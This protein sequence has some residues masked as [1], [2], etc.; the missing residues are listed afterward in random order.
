MM[1]R[2][3]RIPL[4]LVLGLLSSCG[5][6]VSDPEEQVR[7]WLSAMHEAAEEKERG[8]IVAGISPAYIDVRGNSR[9]DIDKL[10][11]VYFFRQNTITLLSN[12]DE[13]NVIGGTAAEVSMTVG[14]AGTNSS[15]LG[16]SADAYRFELEL[17]LDGDDWKLISARWGELG[18]RLR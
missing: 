15:A 17:E 18:E 8:G 2:V 16:I 4:L 12:I 10:L 9:D 3:T 13:V 5:G 14:M 11:R 7:A 6:D 1:A